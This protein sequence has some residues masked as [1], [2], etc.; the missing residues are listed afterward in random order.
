M[1]IGMKSLSCVAV[2]SLL[3]WVGCAPGD[4]NDAGTDGGE[5][6]DAGETPIDAGSDAGPPPGNDGGG[7]SDCPAFNLQAS[8]GDGCDD[9]GLVCRESGCFAPGPSCLFIQCYNGEW[10]NQAFL[11]AGAPDTDAGPEET[12]AGDLIEDAGET[13]A[14]DS[15]AG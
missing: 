6:S 1:R 4:V 8:I 10:V 12:D 7:A 15:D 5:V 3:T 14:G 13:D 9:E 11:D 2:L